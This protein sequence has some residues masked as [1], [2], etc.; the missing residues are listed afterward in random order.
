MRLIALA[1][2]ETEGCGTWGVGGGTGLS[3]QLIR[4]GH[5]SDLYSCRDA[6]RI[7]VR[8]VPRGPRRFI[9]PLARHHIGIL[10]HGMTFLLLELRLPVRSLGLGKFG[11]SC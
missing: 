7:G 2:A 3:R 10:C 11:D 1:N 8:C 5:I 9:R 6:E 4:R